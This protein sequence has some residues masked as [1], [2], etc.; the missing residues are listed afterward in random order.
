MNAARPTF[1]KAESALPKGASRTLVD[2]V[3]MPATASA[4]TDDWASF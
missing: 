4:G 3:G 2:G 1:G